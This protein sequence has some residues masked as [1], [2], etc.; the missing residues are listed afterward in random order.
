MN[1]FFQ[2]SPWN[3]PGA[4]DP[5]Y[6]EDVIVR[7]KGDSH[8]CSYTAKVYVTT[9]ITDDPAAD[10]LMDAR[11]DTITLNIRACDFEFFRKLTRGDEIVRPE[12]FGK[13]YA[14]EEVKTDELMHLLVTA[15]SKKNG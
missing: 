13:K 9:G 2:N 5:M 3:M 15:K 8:P 7:Y 10:D 14:V 6:D 12:F 1:D 4:F 11:T